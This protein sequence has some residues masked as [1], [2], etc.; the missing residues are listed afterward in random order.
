MA[1]VVIFRIPCPLCG[2][3]THPEELIINPNAADGSR[4][5][6]RFMRPMR[7]AVPAARSFDLAR[8][9]QPAPQMCAMR[10]RARPPSNA[11]GR[12]QSHIRSTYLHLQG[13]PCPFS[14]RDSGARP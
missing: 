1:G 9:P 2:H 10:P 11:H 6:L 5:C 13:T 7:P 8:A 14:A 12:P 4:A 3:P